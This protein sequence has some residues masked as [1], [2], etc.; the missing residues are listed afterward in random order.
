MPDPEIPF[1]AYWSS[2]FAKWQGAFA[3]HHALRLAA[4]HAKAE[5]AARN[6]DPAAFDHAILGM[7]IPQ[8]GSFYGLPWLM[9]LIGASAVAGPTVNQACATG[10]RCVAMAVSE[11]ALG[12]ASAVLAVAADRTSNGP[13]IYY[14]D[15]GGPGGTGR[16]E[17]WVLDNFNHDPFAGGAMV[18]TA[19][20]VAARHG[21]TKEEQ[22]AVVLHRYAQYEAALADDRAFQRRFM[23]LPSPVPDRRFEKSVAGLD[24]DEGVYQTSAEKMAGLKPVRA[25]GTV[26]LAAQTHPADGNA[27]LVMTTPEKAQGLSKAPEIRIRV[28]A[29]GEGREEPGHMPAAPII[30][31]RRALASAGLAIGDIDAVK[32]HNPFAVNDIVFARAFGIDWGSMNNFGCSLIYGHP[33]GPTGLRAMIEL[34]EELVLRGGGTGL[35][36]GCA[37]GDTAMAVI[38]TVEDRR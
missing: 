34:I 6:L 5:L 33:Q 32:S 20:A 15:P 1:G 29:I 35:F 18:D 24:G 12:R 9:G 10:A 38:I 31:A 14:P 23:T 22:H 28:R 19:E 8:P 16:H 17:S 13:Q 7:T 4:F 37:A 25:G 21:V 30:A 27:A 3:G 36:Q 2:P 11:I 26:T